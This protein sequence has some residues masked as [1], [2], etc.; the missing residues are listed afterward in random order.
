VIQQEILYCAKGLISFVADL[1]SSVLMHMAYSRWQIRVS[2][3]GCRW[4]QT[5]SLH[6]AFRSFSYQV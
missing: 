6:T 3:S 5:N 2:V 4:R 1:G